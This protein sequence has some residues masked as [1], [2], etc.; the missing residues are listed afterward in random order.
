MSKIIIYMVKLRCQNKITDFF[1][2]LAWACPINSFA[3]K[4]FQNFDVTLCNYLKL[5]LL[6]PEPS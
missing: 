5:T 4:L 6:L 3:A 1:M 2:I